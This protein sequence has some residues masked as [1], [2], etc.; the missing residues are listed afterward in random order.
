MYPGSTLFTKCWEAVLHGKGVRVK[1]QALL[2]GKGTSLTDGCANPR[3]SASIRD[4]EPSP[5]P[6]PQAL[7]KR[8]KIGSRF[9]TTILPCTHRQPTDLRGAQLDE[10][11]ERALDTRR[12]GDAGL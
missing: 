8:G 5:T 3:R 10:M 1:T 11:E 12:I 2:E 4:D 6:L 7:R 9:I